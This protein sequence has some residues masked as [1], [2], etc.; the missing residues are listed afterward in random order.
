MDAA[1]DLIHRNATATSA[2]WI[3][4]YEL[5]LAAFRNP[6]LRVVTER[7]MRESRSLLERHVDASTARAVDAL[8]E[9]LVL[10]NAL[11]TSTVTVDRLREVVAS[12]VSPRSPLDRRR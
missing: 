4:A 6:A 2:D 10:H 12:V 5:Y 8:I 7:W 11:S 9:G 3:I 1:T